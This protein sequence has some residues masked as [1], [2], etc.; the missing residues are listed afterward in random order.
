[1]SPLIEVLADKAEA[2]GYS[3][4]TAILSECLLVIIFY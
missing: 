4:F 1:M 2:K 3:M